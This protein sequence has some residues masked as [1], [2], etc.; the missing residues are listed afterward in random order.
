MLALGLPFLMAGLA[1][2]LPPYLLSWALSRL[3][4]RLPDRRASAGFLSGLAAFPLYWGGIAWA[5][6]RRWGLPT[7]LGAAALGPLSGAF[8]LQAMDRWHR[9]FV[10]TAGLWM[11]VTRPGARGHL[12]R[13]R[14]RLLARADRLLELL[15]P[16]AGEGNP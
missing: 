9:I 15:P 4:G 3:A 5:V 16:A 8:A 13:M 1:L 11:A 10:E 6:A 14:E 2:N 12:R 7:A